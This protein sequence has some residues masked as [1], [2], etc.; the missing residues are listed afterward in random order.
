MIRLQDNV[1]QVYVE[2]SRDFQLF[3][4]L[5]DCINNGVRYD[6][7]SMLL[8]LDPMKVSDR[9][10]NLLCTKVGFFTNRNYDS[11]ILRYILV[12]FPYALKY[13]GSK[14]GIEI[15]VSTILKAEA[16]FRVAEVNDEII[17]TTV[18]IDSNEHVI[19]IFT[20]V[21][22]NNKNALKDFL[23]YIMP[24]GYVYSLET[25]EKHTYTIELTN[26]TSMVTM[27]NSTNSNSQVRGSDRM[28]NSVDEKLNKIDNEFNFSTTFEET[29]VSTLSTA[30]IVGSM[31]NST[32]ASTDSDRNGTVRDVSDKSNKTSQA[33]SQNHTLIKDKSSEV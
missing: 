33:I 28:L 23:K 10:L 1:P 32:D 21:E 14:H 9:M 5:Y 26:D 15:A 30:E 2:Q 3:C 4:R 17:K 12:A 6:I 13:K 16:D 27:I 22:I 8:I 20:T 19:R 31:S 18:E 7:N 25:H 11:K 24:V 29:Y